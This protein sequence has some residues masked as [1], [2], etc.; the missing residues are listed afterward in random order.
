MPEAETG[1]AEAEVARLKAKMW[2]KVYFV[3]TRRVVDPARLAPVV[4]EHY[5]W[6]I[7]LEKA[8]R[9]FASG[10]VFDKDD[11][12]GAGMT[13]FRAGTW[14]EAEE[15]AA[16]DPFCRSGAVEFQLSRW[17]INE[18]RV[19]MHLDFSDQTWHAE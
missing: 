9:V 12:Q 15:L 11:S 4:L 8:G 17:Q 2:K 7:A 5:R 14:D 1:P 13:V 6:I 16:S 18:G 10:P 19:S 3:M